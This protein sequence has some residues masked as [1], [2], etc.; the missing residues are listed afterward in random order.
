LAA[1]QVHH[2]DSTCIEKVGEYMVGQSNQQKG[3]HRQRTLIA[4][5]G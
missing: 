5:L 1:I 4:I 3:R 2:H